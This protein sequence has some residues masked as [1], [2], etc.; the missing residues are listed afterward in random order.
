MY[1]SNLA[2]KNNQNAWNLKQWDYLVTEISNVFRFT[3]EE[4]DVFSNNPTAKLIASIPFVA[5]CVEPERTAIAH[6]CLYVSELKGFQK[7]FTYL[8]GES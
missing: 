3:N 4:K 7:Y 2:L 1:N 5:N 8:T 6:L